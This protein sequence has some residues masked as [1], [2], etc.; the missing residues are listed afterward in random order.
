MHM[1][2]PYLASGELVQIEIPG[3]VQ[4]VNLEVHII[5]SAIRSPGPAAEA[6]WQAFAEKTVDS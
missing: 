3:F 2:A 1:A 5:R 4:R 6:I